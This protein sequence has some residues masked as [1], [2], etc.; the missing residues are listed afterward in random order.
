VF[1][2]FFSLGEFDWRFKAG[3]KIIKSGDLFY[4]HLPT[5][6]TIAQ[7]I[8]SSRDLYRGFA[9]S[10]KLRLRASGPG[11]LVASYAGGTVRAQIG[12]KEELIELTL[13]V[14]TSNSELTIASAEGTVQLTDVYLFNFT[15]T[16]DVRDSLGRPGKHLDDIRALNSLIELGTKPVSHFGVNDN[17]LG[18]VSGT[19]AREK[20]G[21]RWFAWAGPE[22]LTRIVA[23]GSSIRVIGYV[24][25]SM[26]DN[27]DGCRFNVYL[28]SEKALATVYK[29]DGPI[30]LLVPVAPGLKS[31]TV[32]FRLTSS[33][34][35]NT[36]KQQSGRDD[37]NLSFVLTEISAQSEK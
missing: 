11:A 14:P 35:A 6:A 19:W 23:R 26:F 33:C 36:K 24:K 34:V 3:A 1:N 10:T 32:D 28:N 27:A 21:E 29:S 20:D 5:G 2:G 22:V 13:P 16:A 15:Q 31:K 25:P 17:T 18:R 12:T 37:R 30:D 9:K 8:S 7:S 4:A